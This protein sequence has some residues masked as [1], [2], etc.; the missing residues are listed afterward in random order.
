M[1]KQLAEDFKAFVDEK[2]GLH[3]VRDVHLRDDI[4]RGYDP[5]TTPDLRVSTAVNYRV[6]WD[7][8][9]GGMPEELTEINPRNWSGDHC[10]LD[11]RDVKGILFSSEPIQTEDPHMADICPSIL[12]VLGVNH[13][14]DMDGRIIF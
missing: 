10:S 5:G 6:S 9:L 7:T 1:C 11:P 3:P 14:I 2:T 12:K 8:T 4:Y 13:G